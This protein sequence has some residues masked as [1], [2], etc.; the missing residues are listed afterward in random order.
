MKFSN[1]GNKRE[2]FENNP[3]VVTLCHPLTSFVQ[4]LILRTLFAR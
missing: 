3:F 4:S 1:R 2:Q